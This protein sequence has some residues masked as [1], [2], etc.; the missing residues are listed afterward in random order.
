MN[1]EAGDRPTST[2]L[3]VSYTGNPFMDGAIS[4]RW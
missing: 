4:W 1:E 2:H 3:K